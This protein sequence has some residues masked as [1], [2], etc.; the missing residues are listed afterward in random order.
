MGATNIVV[1]WLYLAVVGGVIAAEIGA[2][3][4]RDTR[5]MFILGFFFGPLAWLYLLAA[6]RTIEAEARRRLAVEQRIAEI[7]ADVARESSKGAGAAAPDPS[8]HGA[9]FKSQRAAERRVGRA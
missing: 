5:T 7:R 4:G 8:G 9:D 2:S 3:R 6:G 1:L